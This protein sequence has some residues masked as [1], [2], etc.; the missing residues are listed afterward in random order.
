[1]YKLVKL[2][3]GLELILI[4]R[5]SMRSA[6]VMFCVRTGSVHEKEIN[7]G[8]SHF[9][10]HTVFRKTNERNITEIKK[11]I[12][13]IGGSINA[14]TSRNITM[15][16]SKIPSTEIEKSL[17]ILSDITFNAALEDEDI[18]KESG[19][20]LEEIAMYEDDPVDIAFE[21]LY[22]NIYD[23]DFARPVLGYRDTVKNF[24]SKVL[25]DYYG[26]FFVPQNT[27]VVVVGGFDEDKI[28]SKLSDIK[29][30]NDVSKNKFK[31][32][33]LKEKNISIE[34]TKKELSQHYI[35]NAF[36]APSKIE[37]DY[38]ATMVLNTLLGS[39]MSSLLFTKI[40]EEEG[41]VYEIASDYNA[42]VD[43]GLFL[44][45][46]ATTGEN[47]LNFKN[48]FDEIIYN[49]G[50]RDDLEEWVN[51]GKKRLI[52][53]MTIDIETNTAMGMNALD[54]YLTYDKIIDIDE[55]VGK[56]SLVT[57]EDVKKV[58]KKIFSGY[59]YTSVLKPE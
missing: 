39:G 51:Y 47:V 57:T 31:S 32:P 54:L 28:I 5:N 59:R 24:D 40:R 29:V 19:V 16:Y 36:K 6:S 15:F 41:L 55:I 56:I 2:S 35:I 34:K 14:F 45:F 49:L 17:D 44:F 42:Y 18:K 13:E 1:L 22:K 52:G 38:Y 3:N 50:E 53:K 9:I 46:A 11:P 43:N 23:E 33:V 25:R 48:K 26:N 7:A 27:V 37:D 21:N 12:E 58:S 30:K 4:D 20:I 10:E 8:V